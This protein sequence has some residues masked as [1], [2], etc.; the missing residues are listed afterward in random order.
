M[1]NFRDGHKKSWRMRPTRS[2]RK[3]KRKTRKN[4]K[5][6]SQSRNSIFQPTELNQTKNHWLLVDQSL[7][8]SFTP[9]LR[10]RGN[11]REGLQL[12]GNS[13]DLQNWN[14]VSLHIISVLTL[15]RSRAGTCCER[16]RMRRRCWWTASPS[17]CRRPQA[18][19]AP[20]H[21][22]ASGEAGCPGSSD[23]RLRLWWRGLAPAQRILTSR[24]HLWRAPH[25]WSISKI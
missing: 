5:E 16:W 2:W 1:I 24:C 4:R 12:P 10:N 8:S 21:S 3:V 17:P 25:P 22:P 13:W 14:P 23:L 11:G 9:W 19:S 7:V 20:W 6:K 15:P 18:T